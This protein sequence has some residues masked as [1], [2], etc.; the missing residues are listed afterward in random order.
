MIL[1][2]APV[3]EFHYR[4]GRPVTGH[5]PGHHRSRRGDSGLEFRGHASLLDAPDA[6]RLDL[7]ASLRDPFGN[8]LVRVHSQRKA[9]P[10]TLVADLSASMGFEGARRRLDV[11]ADFV[12]SLAQS[13]WRTGD[14]FGFLGCDE[15]VREDLQLAQTR[16]GGAGDLRQIGSGNIGATNVLRTGRKG[17]AA[18]T[19]LLDALKGVLA[20]QSGYAGGFIEHYLLPLIYPAALTRELQF[21]LAGFVV[22]VNLAVYAWVWRRKL[23]QGSTGAC[24]RRARAP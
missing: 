19:L 9:I 12:E 20:G 11:V 13:A 1:P 4:V 15:T 8:W 10:V 16:A 2:E 23:R 7:H 22:L 17:L 18:A 21:A 6:R 5:F 14:S 24:A 3:R